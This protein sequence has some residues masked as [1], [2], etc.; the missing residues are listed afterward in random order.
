MRNMRKGFSGLVPEEKTPNEDRLVMLCDGVFAI[1][2]TLLVL[3]IGI[4]AGLSSAKQIEDALQELIAPGIIYLMTFLII[5]VYWRFHRMLMQVVQR[6]DNAFLSLT[7]LFLA[8]I[9]IFPA[10][11]KLI[12][13]YGGYRLI[14]IVYTLGLS[15]CGFSA[16]ALWFYATH[17]HRLVSPDLPQEEI[18][19][20]T[21]SLLINPLIYCAS[22]LLLIWIPDGSAYFICF[23]W[24]LIGYTQR[25][26]RVIYKRWLAKPVQD[27]LHHV[28]DSGHLSEPAL[29]ETPAPAAVERPAEEKADQ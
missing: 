7:F 5:A 25:V 3:D 27:L 23:S 21:I 20:R 14:V 29:P 1:A 2:V 26:G 10:T 12:G 19:T 22:L 18:D 11:F 4:P 15:G 13:V 9:A 24:A 17:K 28:H 8:F 16:F 6:L